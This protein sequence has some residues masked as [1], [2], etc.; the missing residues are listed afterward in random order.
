MLMQTEE[1]PPDPTTEEELQ[2]VIGCWE[3]DN[4]FPPG[5]RSQPGCP[6]PSA[7]PWTHEYVSKAN[8][9]K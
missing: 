9:I 2:V 1:F 5:K 6:A 3:R 7:Q 4:Q 8:W